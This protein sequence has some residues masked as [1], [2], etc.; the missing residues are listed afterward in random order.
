MIRKENE[1]QRVMTSNHLL[2]ADLA[3]HFVN[4]WHMTCL[5]SNSVGQAQT[6][7][8]EAIGGLHS[9]SISLEDC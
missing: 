8:S 5:S 1:N 7:V 6:G 2:F 9:F 3:V 4:A